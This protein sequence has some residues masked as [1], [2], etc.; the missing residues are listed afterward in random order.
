MQL[1]GADRHRLLLRHNSLQHPSLY[2]RRR[3]HC[4][5]GANHSISSPLTLAH[6]SQLPHQLASDLL[7]PARARR[8]PSCPRHAQRWH[9]A[10]CSSC[11]APFGIDACHS[12]DAHCSPSAGRNRPAWSR[13]SAVG[14]PPA[15]LRLPRSRQCS[16]ITPGPSAPPAC[17]T[18]PQL[19]LRSRSPP[20]Q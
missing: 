19:L 6:R 17:A 8:R 20:G 16:G 3:S 7:S 9:A 11:L 1:A 4:L 14:R 12:A 15:R 2:G 5:T 18:R 10:R 13:P